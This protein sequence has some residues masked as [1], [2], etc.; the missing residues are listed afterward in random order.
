MTVR[1]MLALIR[2]YQVAISPLAGGVCRYQPTCS[3]Y[4][5]AALLNFGALKGSRLA[6][7]RL[8]RCHPLGGSGYDPLPD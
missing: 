6:M 2:F 8:L 4:A 5:Y 3:H 7:S 1:A